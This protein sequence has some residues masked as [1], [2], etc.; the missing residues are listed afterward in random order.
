[1]EIA[2]YM[3]AVIGGMTAFGLL[4]SYILIKTI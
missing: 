2:V 3:L 1:M 4:I